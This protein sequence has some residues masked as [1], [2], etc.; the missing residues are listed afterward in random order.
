MGRRLTQDA[1]ALYGGNLVTMGL[2][3]LLAIFL[4]RALGPEGYGVVGLVITVTA[5]VTVFLD[6][7]IGEA[8]IKYTTEYQV[9]GDSPQALAVIRL[10]YLVDLLLGLGAFVIVFAIAPLAAE[11]TMHR[12][13]GVE[14]LRLYALVPLVATINETSA[15]LLSIFGRFRL[16]SLL[17]MGGAV[18]LFVLPLAGVAFGLHGVIVGYVLG[19]ALPTLAYS[20]ISLSM[21]GRHFGGVKAA[22]LA[23]QGRAVFSFSL[24]TTLSTSFKS[25]TRYLDVLILGFFRSPAEVG[26]YRV[27]LAGGGLLGT[28]SGP[29]S[30]AIY[31]RLAQRWAAGQQQQ[32]KGL[33]LRLSVVMA[34]ISV[35]GAVLL[36]LLAPW[37][38]PF[39]VGQSFIPSLPAFYV[40]V[41]G[42]V[43]NNIICWGRPFALASGRPQLSTGA[44][45]L[46]ALV[47]A[48]VNLA[49]VPGLGI[50]GA[51]WA[52]LAMHVTAA[53]YYG[54][55]LLRV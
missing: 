2:Q 35:P 39:L 1:L 21:I 31:P 42:A 53:L 54:L 41:W 24:H 48:G 8:V 55:F 26:Y 19:E 29:V 44:S 15:A 3:M 16:M 11:A 52:Y 18:L 23:A 34:G 6:V 14:L 50:V 27:A 49:L 20:A 33:L 30:T 38:L 43:A 22:S 46:A 45:L 12:P 25:L 28:V 17:Q 10:G 9:K 13:D 5:T 37:I 51:A 32:V 40:L 4:A 7:R 36:S 47:V